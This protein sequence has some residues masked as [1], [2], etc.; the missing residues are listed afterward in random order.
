M[1]HAFKTPFGQ[2]KCLWC[3]QNKR[4]ADP[5]CKITAEMRDALAAFAKEHGRNWKTFLQRCWECGHYPD[6]ADTQ[7]LQLARNVGGPRLLMRLSNALMAKLTTLSVL[8]G[9]V[10]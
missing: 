6:K 5:E 4:F 9:K 7:A 3:G 2:C 1:R 8:Q 10:D